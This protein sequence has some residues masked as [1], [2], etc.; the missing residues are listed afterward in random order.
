MERNAFALPV[1]SQPTQQ[2][3]AKE[4]PISVTQMPEPGDLIAAFSPQPGRCFRM[5]YDHQLQADHCR[6]V[7]E[8]KRV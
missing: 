4:P 7:P 2:D 3:D 6:G 5:V 1:G 8:W